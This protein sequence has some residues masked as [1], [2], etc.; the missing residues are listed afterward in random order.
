MTRELATL[1]DAGMS[2]DQSLRLMTELVENPAVRDLLKELLEAIRGGSTLA[3]AL[4]AHDEVFPEAYVGMVRA[5]ETGG[6]LN[7]VLARLAVYLDNAET[8][9]PETGYVPLS[10]AQYDEMRARLSG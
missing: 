1:L 3:D 9:V 5:G 7:D 6:S 8:L 2:L 10:P 4:A